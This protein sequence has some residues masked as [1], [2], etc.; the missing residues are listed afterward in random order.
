MY[1]SII[2]ISLNLVFLTRSVTR[3]L[4]DFFV[5]IEPPP[6]YHGF[7]LAVLSGKCRPTPTPRSDQ[8]SHFD[9]W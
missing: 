6:F 4:P 5:L 7:I 3:E 8:N 1:F 9:F 2:Y